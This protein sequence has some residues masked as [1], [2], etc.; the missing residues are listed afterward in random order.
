MNGIEEFMTKNDVA[1][2]PVKEGLVVVPADEA[3]KAGGGQGPGDPGP[4]NPFPQNAD[5]MLFRREL[6]GA[7]CAAALR[8]KD[9][10]D[11][12]SDLALVSMGLDNPEIFEHYDV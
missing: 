7:A 6:A 9:G 2:V 4:I 5:Y 10:I 8:L 1:L 12:P 11:S 3:L